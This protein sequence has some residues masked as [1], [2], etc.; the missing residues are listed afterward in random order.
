MG[1]NKPVK[2]L[3][4]KRVASGLR[5]ARPSSG[6]REPITGRKMSLSLSRWGR[7]LSPSRSTSLNLGS[8]LPPL[9]K[10][11]R[12]TLRVQ[13]RK[14]G[15]APSSYRRKPLSMSIL[16]SLR[17]DAHKLACSGTVA[18]KYLSP[19]GMRLWFSWPIATTAQQLR[20]IGLRATQLTPAKK[21]TPIWLAGE[22]R[23]ARR[24]AN[25]FVR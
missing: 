10:L 3:G 8:I 1:S 22:K 18:A 9:K 21:L 12:Y 24:H 4:W 15:L 25:T 7:C 19:Y 23:L 2:P 17:T 14:Q 6:R 16:L 5:T 13:S 11:S 20:T